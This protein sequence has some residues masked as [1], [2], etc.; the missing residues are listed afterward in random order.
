MQVMTHAGHA[1]LRVQ[2]MGH[3]AR[4]P[5]PDELD[6]MKRALTLA[7]EQGA[8]GMSTGLYYP[9]SGFAGDEELVALA[10]VVA[11]FDRFHAAHIRNEAAGRDPFDWVCDLIVSEEG[12]V[13]I[14]IAS[15][16]ESI[17]A[18]FIALPFAM[19]GSD[20]SPHDGTPHPRLYGAFP[21][22]IR[23]FV[24]ELKTM[25]LERAVAKMTDLPARRL[26]LK[27]YGRIERNYRADLVL[28]DP[29]RFADTASY[30][31]P[32]S[33]PV[34]LQ[35]VIIDGRPVLADNRLTPARPG[36]FIST[37]PICWL[38]RRERCALCAGIVYP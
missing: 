23:R 19:I 13:N 15:M 32:R 12:E 37:G 33:F 9:P 8:A 16:D 29:E 31:A 6:G 3:A 35:T 36:G 18:R 38:C 25:T 22:V 17:V 30:E 7:L 28:F 10:R 1:A 27:N 20:G 26:G 2:A 24:R 21:R 11:E 34:G 14:I 5:S 4:P